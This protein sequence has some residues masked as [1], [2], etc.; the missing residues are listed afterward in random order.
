VAFPQLLAC[1]RRAEVGVAVADQPQGSLGG[2]WRK[3]VVAGLAATARRQSGRAFRPVAQHQPPQLAGGDPEPLGRQTRLQVA[4]DNRL[5]RLQPVEFAHALRDA[6]G[7]CRHLGCL[8]KNGR[9]AVHTLDSI[10]GGRTFLFSQKRTFQ[11]SHYTLWR[12][13]HVL[14]NC[15]AFQAIDC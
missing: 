9:T 5:N 12:I 10:P 7:F 13:M 11:L 8:L 6:I 15:T 4:F 3:L 14:G 2:P 1:Q